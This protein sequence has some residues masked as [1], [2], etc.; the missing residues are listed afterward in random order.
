M[1]K[2]TNATIDLT[3]SAGLT[4]A[5]IAAL[6]NRVYTMNELI[7]VGANIDFSM[8]NGTTP[9]Y[10]AAMKGHVH[11]MTV[12]LDA[13]ANAN[14]LMDADEKDGPRPLAQVANNVD[15][16][17]LLEEHFKFYPT[18]IKPYIVKPYQSH[19]AAVKQLKAHILPELNIMQIVDAN[20]YSV[21]DAAF[22]GNSN[23]ITEFIKE[24]RDINRRLRPSGITPL[25]I[26]TVSGHLKVVKVL[27]DAGAN[28]KIDTYNG[29]VLDA[30][31]RGTQQIHAGIA[32]R[33]EGHLARYPAGIRIN[34]LGR[35]QTTKPYS[36]PAPVCSQSPVA[37]HKHAKK[38]L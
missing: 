19:R 13:S 23:L 28:A 9:L 21:F 27:L 12:L 18:G 29:S 5:H 1:L 14:I 22:N 24:G 26:A 34:E 31:K 6:Q 25:Y 7:A 20:A 30:V 15:A 36:K 4:A 16:K 2:E 10:I 32:T 37:K 8:P 17:R 3:T 33:L 11:I 35:A 38:R